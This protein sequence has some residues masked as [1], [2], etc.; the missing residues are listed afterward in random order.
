[1][2]PPLINR[3]VSSATA[4]PFVPE[5]KRPVVPE[6]SFSCVV[7]PPTKRVRPREM[8]EEKPA[9]PARSVVPTAAPAPNATAQCRIPAVAPNPAI[10]SGRASTPA[11]A[12]AHPSAAPMAT[13][14]PFA[15]GGTTAPFATTTSETPFEFHPEKPPQVRWFSWSTLILIAGCV[16]GYFQYQRMQHATAPALAAVGAAAGALS[17]ATEERSPSAPATSSIATPSTALKQAKATINDDGEKPKAAYDLVEKLLDQPNAA[18]DAASKPAAPAA[19]QTSDPDSAAKPKRDAVAALLGND[20]EFFVPADSP[21]PSLRFARWVRAV[22]IGGTRLHDHPRVLVGAAAFT[23]GDVVDA[24][25]G[26]V[27]DG[28]NA[29]RRALRFRETATGAVIERRL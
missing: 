28:Y 2:P 23:F 19:V 18:V 1:M 11:P 8:P 12:A 16:A 3:L 6:I 10:A 17:A 26:I 25:L 27:L 7:D 24:N 20:G 4:A 15:K 29:E 9:A 22:K 5:E 13:V 21:K 14:P